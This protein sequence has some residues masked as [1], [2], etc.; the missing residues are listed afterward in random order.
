MGPMVVSSKKSVLVY[1]VWGLEEIGKTCE[2]KILLMNCNYQIK[3]I[4]KTHSMDWWEEIMFPAANYQ[5]ITGIGPVIS[6]ID[7]NKLM[8]KY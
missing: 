4:I 8:Y 7:E 5:T 1:I 2:S 6:S 3:V